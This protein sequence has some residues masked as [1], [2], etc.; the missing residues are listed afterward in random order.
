[1][2]DLLKADR[3]GEGRTD[4][5]YWNES[6]WFS[7]SIPE[8]RIHGMIQY[9]FRPNMGM[10]N[11]G[12]VLWDSSGQFQWNCL[13]YN[14]SHLQGVTPGAE[15]FDMTARNSLTVKVLEPLTRYKID[16]GKEGFVLDLTWEAVGPVHELVTG[17]PGQKATASFH[18][19]QPGRMKG[20]IHRHGESFAVDS[21][22]MRDTSYGAREYESL[23]YG[24]YFW[25]IAEGSSFHAL[26]MGEKD[27]VYGREANCIG[28][29]I[30]KDGEMASLVSGKRR[31][32]EF[33]QFGPSKVEFEG[34]DKLG[35]TM[36][37][38]GTID[39]GLVFTG[40]TDHSV[41]WSLAEWEWDGA[42][43]WGDNQEFSPAEPFRQM[44]RGE[45]KLGG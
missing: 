40:Y 41:V 26:C 22:S 38:T 42:T 34:A 24:G 10:L 45:M 25:G 20:T 8:Q 13:Y 1:M 31:V 5:P 44:A 11:G 15:K 28:G 27:V 36:R 39:P 33:G 16:Y 2:T 3:F 30:M 14:W 37:V 7:V 43:L 32:L 35:R 4:S 18:I 29:Y 17:D 21:F 9:Y 23:A 12:P 19:E 6:V